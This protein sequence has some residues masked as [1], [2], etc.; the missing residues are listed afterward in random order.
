MLQVTTSHFQERTYPE[1]FT[2]IFFHSFIHLFIY[3]FSL[4]LIF[5]ITIVVIFFHFF[6]VTA[7][8]YLDMFHFAEGFT[9][10]HTIHIAINIFYK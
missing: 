2:C 10:M 3:C 7:A 1:Y 6:N 4:V 5:I 9:I 8:D